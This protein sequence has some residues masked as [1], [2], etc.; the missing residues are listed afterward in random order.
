MIILILLLVSYFLGSIPF[1]FLVARFVRK[2]DIR[3]FGSGNIGAT[4]VFRVVGKEW[5]VLVF[6]LDFLKGFLPPFMMKF[7][8][9]GLA[10]SIYI[11]CAILAVCGHNWTPFLKF[12][13]G[14]GISTSL[15]A[16]VA[17]SF[18]FPKLWGSIGLAI[19][20]WIVV[21]FIF[22]Y[23]SLAS[24]IAAAVFFVSSLILS[25]PIEVKILCF[26][27]FIFIIVRHK[28]NIKKLISRKEHR[29]QRRGKGT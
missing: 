22:R 3:Q 25:L 10:N 9:P 23:V 16:I 11:I 26:V 29:F 21:F 14:K 7:F 4:N 15:G 17:L 1:G 8:L 12:K 28:S 20:A 19:C 5:G 18:I 13:G 2:I 24:I 27:L 6:I